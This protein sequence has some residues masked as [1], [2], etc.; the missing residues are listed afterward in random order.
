MGESC[1]LTLARKLE[2]V[3]RKTVASSKIIPTVCLHRL[4]GGFECPSGQMLTWLAGDKMGLLA[5]STCG[6]ATTPEG[7]SEPG[8][9][10]ITTFWN[11]RGERE[12]ENSRE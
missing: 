3:Q 8:A 7:E 12:T 1:P 5:T 2:A 9:G 10:V 11:E 4:R 6:V